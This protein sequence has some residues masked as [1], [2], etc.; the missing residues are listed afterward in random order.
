MDPHKIRSIALVRLSALGDV[1]MML[2]L[3]RT[4]QG[5]LPRARITWIIGRAAHELVRGLDGVEFVCLDNPGTLVAYRRF[6]RM[7]RGRRFDVL[8]ATQASLRANLLYPWIR[9][10]VKVGFDRTRARDGQW[11]FTN[12]RIPFARQHLLESFL[13]FG[14]AVGVRCQRPDCT[15]PLAAAERQWAHRQI[16]PGNAPL[17]VVNPGASVAERNWPARRYAQLIDTAQA[18]WGAR[19]VM[20]GGADPEERAL[21][22][23]IRGEV[24]GEVLDLSGRTTVRQLAAVLEVADCVVAPDTGPAHIAAAMG[25]PVV[26]LYAVAPAWLSAPHAYRD[27]VVDRYA[28]AVRT[29]LGRDPQQVPWGTRVHDPRAMELIEVA[30][31]VQMLARVFGEGDRGRQR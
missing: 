26:G 4:L 27:L 2:A 23:R 10:G 3:V 13:A 7:M 17:L 22:G 30:D 16:G 24:S 28:D 25:T 9:A 15:I 21:A 31:V 18:R 20:T 8:L 11:L 19:V 29:L 5:S 14:E 6:R 1:T 12:R